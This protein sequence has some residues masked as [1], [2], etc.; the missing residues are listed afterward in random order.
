LKEESIV[1]RSPKKKIEAKDD[2]ESNDIMH[3]SKLEVSPTSIEV[4]PSLDTFKVHGYI[5][6]SKLL[7]MIYAGATLNFMDRNQVKIFILQFKR[8]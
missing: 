3:T 7:M 1:E 8:K 5:K 4:L 6:K 2:D